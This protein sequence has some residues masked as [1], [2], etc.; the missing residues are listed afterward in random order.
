M[1]RAK[2]VA[3]VFFILLFLA[4][5]ILV[6]FPYI[7]GALTYL[8]QR[9]EARS[10][11]TTTES[12]AVTIE[13]TEA[14][15]A[16]ESPT[17]PDALLEAAR[18]YNESLITDGQ[19]MTSSSVFTEA[20]LSLSDFGYEDD[21]FAVLSISAIDLEMPIYLGAS[22]DNLTK[23]ACI[24][25]H[26]S[27]PIGGESTNSVIAG[28]RGWRGATMFKQV[29]NLQIGDRITITNLWETL[30][31]EVTEKQTIYSSDAGAI[32][33]REGEDLVTLFTC[34]YAANGIK[35]R[36]LVICTRVTDAQPE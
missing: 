18:A 19:S 15:P 9:Q 17:E 26:T 4:G 23:G 14:V 32:L 13:A 11:L 22:Y 25:G 16:E 30:T 10:F 6:L 28:H 34:D 35:L 2:K 5:F 3:L 20:P 8:R 36:S 33:I 21:M 31:Y 27:L 7:N 12:T 1:K 24:M 29:P